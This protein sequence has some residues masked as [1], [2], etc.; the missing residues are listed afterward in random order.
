MVERRTRGFWVRVGG[1]KMFNSYLAYASLTVMA[2]VLKA[3]FG[4]YAMGILAA[5]GI[6]SASV[7]YE[8]RGKQ[9]VRASGS[10]AAV[11]A[12]EEAEK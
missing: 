3:S 4:E 5:L 9:P 10:D 11:A 2:L 1:R 8:D 12:A 7:A 6:S